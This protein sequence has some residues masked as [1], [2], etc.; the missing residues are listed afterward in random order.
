MRLVEAFVS[1]PCTG[2]S[3]YKWDEIGKKDYK[4]LTD[5]LDDFALHETYSC[6]RFVILRSWQK[7]IVGNISVYEVEMKTEYQ[8]EHPEHN[9]AEYK[10]TLVIAN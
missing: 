6:M 9:Q 5:L 10:A 1:A 2:Y 4:H 8:Q 3:P 7:R